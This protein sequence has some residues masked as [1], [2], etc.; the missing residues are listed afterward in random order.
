MTEAAP[1]PAAEAPPVPAPP[2]LRRAPRW[3]AP[4]FCVLAA[5][6]VPWTLWLA[7][8]LP[9][10]HL[11]SHYDV[12]WSGFDIALAASLLA[13]GVG[14]FRHAVW[15]QGVAAS[16][17]TLLVCDAWFDVTLSAD[18]SEQSIAL[19]TAVLI[20]LPL[21]VACLFVAR[22]SEQMAERARGYVARVRR[23]RL[24]G[25]TEPPATP[26]AAE[27]AAEPDPPPS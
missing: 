14:V 2:V 20:E 24:R 13:T 26:G 11:S 21:A 3:A 9:T 10:R 7:V 27:R 16:A 5:A 4:V 25:R 18:G 17:A 15:T 12:A 6:L 19:V 1:A 8:S 23:V 22:D